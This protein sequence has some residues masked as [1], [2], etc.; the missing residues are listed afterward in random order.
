MGVILCHIIIMIYNGWM[1]LAPPS[2]IAKT[3]LYYETVFVESGFLH[4]LLNNLPCA[5]NQIKYCNF[6]TQFTV[7][8]FPNSK[9]QLQMHL[10]CLH[11]KKGE[12]EKAK[13][14]IFFSK[15]HKRKRKW[16]V[17]NVYLG[18]YTLCHWFECLKVN[19]MHLRFHCIA[20]V[21]N[22][23]TF[24]KSRELTLIAKIRVPSTIEN[25]LRF[26]A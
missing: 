4:W 10:N 6:V 11:L 16:N 9:L 13:F 22:Y 25:S 23:F 2:K 19:P 12:N 7:S 5:I 17:A 15:Q 20:A 3:V 18:T 24:K 8:P 26:S 1:V 21:V 14:K